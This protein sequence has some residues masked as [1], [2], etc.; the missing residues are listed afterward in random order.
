ML[1]QGNSRNG[2][3]ILKRLIKKKKFR[4][5]LLL[6]R[7]ANEKKLELIVNLKRKLNNMNEHSKQKKVFDDD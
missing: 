6:E 1:A 3:F 7:S 4:K 5:R 2:S